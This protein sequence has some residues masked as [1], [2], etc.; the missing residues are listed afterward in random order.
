MSDKN[1]FSV[2]TVINQDFA[3]SASRNELLEE[4]SDIQ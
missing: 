3:G 4:I 2:A 1:V